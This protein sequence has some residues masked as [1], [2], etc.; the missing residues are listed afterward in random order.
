[1][2]IPM[3]LAATT[4]G[5][6]LLAIKAVALLTLKALA[7]SKIAFMI[8]ALMIIKKLV[9]NNSEKLDNSINSIQSIKISNKFQNDVS[10][11]GAI[12]LYDAL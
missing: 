7:L 9:E 4:F 1:M 5:W 3:Y 10:L 12:E 6:S 11:S 2:F 8:A